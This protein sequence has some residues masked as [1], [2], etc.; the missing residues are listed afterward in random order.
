M[1]LELNEATISSI[2]RGESANIE[3]AFSDIERG[4]LLTS[5]RKCVLDSQLKSLISK[6]LRLYCWKRRAEIGT[7][8]P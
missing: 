8:E 1:K 6:G 7:V 5:K 3:V 2:K 4:K